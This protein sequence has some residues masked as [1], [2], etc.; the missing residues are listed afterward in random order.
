MSDWWT[1]G[2]TSQSGNITVNSTTGSTT[3][4]SVPH[5]NQVYIDGVAHSTK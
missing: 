4:V 5:T 1:N 2:D 3:G